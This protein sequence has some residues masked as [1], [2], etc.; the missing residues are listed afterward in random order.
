M[1]KKREKIKIENL[2]LDDDHKENLLQ[3]I[4]LCPCITSKCGLEFIIDNLNNENIWYFICNFDLFCSINWGRF[5]KHFI[6]NDKELINIIEKK[7]DILSCTNRLEEKDLELIYS[8]ATKLILKRN[9]SILRFLQFMEN[10]TYDPHFSF[11]SENIRYCQGSAT[12]DFWRN[13]FVWLEKNLGTEDFLTNGMKQNLM[14]EENKKNIEGHN[15]KINGE[16]KNDLNEINTR[17]ELDKYEKNNPEETI[18]IDKNEID[19]SEK[20]NEI[21]IEGTKQIE[22]NQLKSINENDLKKIILTRRYIGNGYQFCQEDYWNVNINDF[23][24]FVEL[25]R[26]R[27]TNISYYESIKFYRI[28]VLRQKYVKEKNLKVDDDSYTNMPSHHAKKMKKFDQLIKFE[29]GCSYRFYKDV[30]Y[31]SYKNFFEVIQDIEE[32]DPNYPGLSE[33]KSHLPYL[34]L[35]HWP[36]HITIIVLSIALVAIPWLF[37]SWGLGLGL[38]FVAV[39]PIGFCCHRLYV[40]DY[41]W[42]EKLYLNKRLNKYDHNLLYYINVT[43]YFGSFIDEKLC[44]IG[45][46]IWIEIKNYFKNNVATLESELKKYRKIADFR[47]ITLDD[48]YRFYWKRDNKLMSDINKIYDDAL[49]KKID[50]IAIDEI[51]ISHDFRNYVNR[52]GMWRVD[53]CK[54]FI[55]KNIVGH[56]DDIKEMLKIKGRCAYFRYKPNTNGQLIQYDI[57]LDLSE[58][59]WETLKEEHEKDKNLNHQNEKP[60]EDMDTSEN[61]INISSKQKF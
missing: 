37:L 58:L 10:I 5:L 11:R 28:E 16:Q 38:S 55:N 2:Q 61:I 39:G 32:C 22:T 45:N 42:A 52:F 54:K 51:S 50:E 43:E 3:L 53:A 20:I 44:S 41:T 6:N 19:E 12:Y 17:I 59:L 13:Y 7:P 4:G 46:D 25:L 56:L 24:I 21:K 35:I 1:R 30:Y 34:M 27:N 48:V 36:I 8:L 57:S 40:K 18:L 60:L 23:S 47:K 49:D 33:L 31:G 9:R 14:L 29:S 26:R 15:I